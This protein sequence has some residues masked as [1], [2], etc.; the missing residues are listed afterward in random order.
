MGRARVGDVIHFA[1]S[2]DERLPALYVVVW[3][4]LPA[5]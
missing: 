2:L 4:W 1:R 5:W 3:H